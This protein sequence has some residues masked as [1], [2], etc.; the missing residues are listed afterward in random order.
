MAT[1]YLAKYGEAVLDNGYSICF[2]RPG[3]KR[4]VGDDWEEKVHGPKALAKAVSNGKA[5]YGVGIK[6]KKT[7]GVDID[8]YDKK[9][10]KHMISFTEDLCGETLQRVGNAP[11]TLLV[12]RT[13]KPFPKTQSKV[14]I[15]DKGRSIKL[16]VLG[17]GQQFVAL[18][19]HPDTKEPYRWKDKRHVGNVAWEEL[20]E[21]TQDDA[22][23]IVEEFERLCEDRGWPR[24]TTANALARRGNV[25]HNDPFLTDK[26][27][28]QIP[29][30]ELRA[31]LDL[32]PN[33]E[34]YEMWFFVGMALYHQFDGGDE[35]LTMW[36][37][38]S[39]Q[40][41]NYDQDALDEKWATFDIEGKKREPLTAR[42]ILKKAAENTERI[43]GEEY[44]RIKEDLADAKDI[45][46]LT[47]VTDEIK[48]IEFSKVMRE[49]LMPV[50]K[51]AFKKL[52]GNVPS[53]GLIRDMIR[54][55]SA[56]NKTT[57]TWLDTFVYV[58]D[59]EAFYSTKTRTVISHKAFDASFNR[60]MMS[61][62]DRLEGR[63]NPEHTASHAALN[64]YEIPI[65][66]SR[67]YLPGEDELFRMNGKDCIN[68]YSDFTVPEAVEKLTVEDK[69]AIDIVRK[70]FHHLFPSSAKDRKLLLDWLCYIVQ[71]GK[72]SKWGILVQ[73]AEADGKTFFYTLMGAVLGADNVNTII[74]ESMK[75]KYSPWAQGSQFL[76]IE[77]VRLHGI[78]RWAILNRVKPYI[79]NDMVSVRVMN[80]DF[81]KAINT[82]NYFMTTN[83]KDGIPVSDEDTRYYP[84]FSQWQRK[85]V[86]DKFKRDN[87]NYYSDL[88]EAVKNHAPALRQWMLSV[89]LSDN[90]DPDNRAPESADRREM[91]YLNKTDEQEV[92]EELLEESTDPL[93][94]RV[95]L[96][97]SAWSDAMVAREA[98][99]PKGH[100]VK[101]II[102]EQGFKWLGRAFINGK[103]RKL[104][105]QEPARFLDKKGKLITKAVRDYL[106]NHDSL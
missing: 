63:S 17:A 59:E 39:S 45:P 20:P 103:T 92:F 3:E 102:S 62:K 69:W 12:Y 89:K 9:I 32:V 42:F 86:L 18:H 76:L 41:E 29:A 10:V 58:Q 34:D 78:D 51:A 19:V 22:Y 14:Y 97:S 21:I 56:E 70:H 11:K 104:W 43:A 84:L 93:V 66:G 50:V 82:V 8:C 47:R 57:P 106:K 91:V 54:F 25:D 44:E 68:S 24:K 35:G 77:E 65:V 75:E 52:T 101:R 81:F 61:K 99:I 83:H 72:R 26:D 40:A 90:F 6:T 55:E 73:G 105:S 95:L 7:P 67:V 37:E 33:P 5:G 100:A 36:H 16:E 64:R 46:Q 27:K 48:K 71:T 4:P 2:I 87:P 94:G 15:D 98:F 74:G 30:S 80:R 49:S 53:I 60:H 79:T 13:D 1:E 96:D 28:I 38:W 31:K 23:E 88:H 85:E